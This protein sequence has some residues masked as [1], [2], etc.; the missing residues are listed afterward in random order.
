MRA[1][2]IA[3]TFGP[4]DLRKVDI[5]QQ[6]AS[7]T[8]DSRDARRNYERALQRLEQAPGDNEL[9]LAGLLEEL[10]EVDDED[11]PIERRIQL[12]QRALDIYRQHGMPASPRSLDV[13]FK[14]ACLYKRSGH[15]QAAQRALQDV[16]AGYETDAER[17]D[18]RVPDVV[19][20]LAELYM[21]Y[22]SS[23]AAQQLLRQYL[24]RFG[25]TKDDRLRYIAV[26]FATQLGWFYVLDGDLRAAQQMFKEAMEQ[27]LV[28]LKAYGYP[29]QYVRFNEINFWLD[30]CYVKLLA[31]GPSKHKSCQ[32]AKKILQDQGPDLVSVYTQNDRSSEDMS[33]PAAS[34]LP[35]WMIERRQAYAGVVTYLMKP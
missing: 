28:W 32:G 14:L 26:R 16:L 25:A 27:R 13:L 17:A 31:H 20:E 12:L 22:R 8:D 9:R 34:D 18:L 19:Q 10:A 4:A 5:L 35:E 7:L 21:E 15:I 33:A 6:L 23:V 11:D 3:Q 30:L 29:R 2:D 24:A 1:L